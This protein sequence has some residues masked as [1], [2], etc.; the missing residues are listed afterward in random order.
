MG[1]DVEGTD[2]ELTDVELTVEVIDSMA[3]KLIVESKNLRRISKDM[4]RWNDLGYASEAI[5]VVVN[6]MVHLRLDL[7]VTRPIRELR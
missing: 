3:D 2:V 1:T 7:L 4:R 6:L 5:Q